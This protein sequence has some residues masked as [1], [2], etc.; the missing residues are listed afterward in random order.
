MKVS[1]EGTST[2][3]CPTERDRERLVDMSA[4]VKKARTISAASLGLALLASTPWVGVAPLLLL[5]LVGANL[6]IIEGRLATAKRPE[7]VAAASMF[8][9]QTVVAGGVGLTGGPVSPMIPWIVVPTAVVAARFRRHVV[10][11]FAASAV[12]VAVGPVVALDPA[13]FLDN[14]VPV[15]ATL[16]LLVSIVAVTMALMN[17]ELQHRA[18]AVLDPLTG[19]LNRKAL[20]S[21]FQEL[22]QQAR[23]SEASVC[24]IAADLDHFKNVNDAH[25]HPR[26]DDVLQDVTYEMRKR[27]RTFELMYRVGGEEFLVVLPGVDLPE[28]VAVAERLRQAVADRK[29]AGLDVTISLGVAA[30]C[31]AEVTYDGLLAAADRALY[32]AKD[33]GRNSVRADG[34]D[35]LAPLLE[36]LGVAVL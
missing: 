14:P 9:L 6:A 5:A 20:D 34:H 8:F 26:G 7:Y 19:L 31:G 29:P 1:M 12:L 15:F 35:D 24:V 27:L 18:D 25:G 4:R 10:F 13:A 11:A 30:A 2:W 3:L 33:A 22:E 36:A 23:Q 28:G 17:A 21:R 32:D 16:G